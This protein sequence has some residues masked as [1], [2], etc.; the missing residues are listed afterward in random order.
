M[1]KL[2]SPFGIRHVFFYIVLT[3]KKFE[4]TYQIRSMKYRQYA[5]IHFV[6]AER[7]MYTFTSVLNKQTQRS[8]E[9]LLIPYVVHFIQ[10]FTFN[11]KL[12]R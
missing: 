6:P 12:K 9:M 8:Q 4:N 11:L 2:Y 3:P 7:R 5:K 1:I 10:L